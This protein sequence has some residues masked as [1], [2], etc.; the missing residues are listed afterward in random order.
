MGRV[1]GASSA[2]AVRAGLAVVLLAG[3]YVFVFGLLATLAWLTW[4]V[5][6]TYPG[7]DAHQ[8]LSVLTAATFVAL[9]VP[10]WKVSR[11]RPVPPPGTPLPESAAPEL[12]AEV[13]AIAAA[14]GTRP[15]REI[16]LVDKVNAMVWDDAHLLGP[17]AGRRYLYVGAPLLHGLDLLAEGR[18]DELR[19]NGLNV[20]R[21]I[22]G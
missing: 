2:A 20:P 12:W 3:F 6:V 17:H 16:R 7:S 10:V 11:A 9:V 8:L 1:T 22:A 14:V 18:A 21:S 5:W 19:A 13:R 4:W 15:P